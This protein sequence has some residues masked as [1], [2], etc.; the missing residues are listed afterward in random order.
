[1]SGATEAG[2]LKIIDK[3]DSSLNFRVHTSLAPEFGF[4]YRGAYYAVTVQVSEILAIADAKDDAEIAR[5][6]Q[7]IFRRVD[8]VVTTEMFD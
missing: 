1:M 4:S 6:T 7:N 5:L 3:T 8:G 2:F